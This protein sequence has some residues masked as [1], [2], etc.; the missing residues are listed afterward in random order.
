MGTYLGG[1]QSRY[2]SS[3]RRKDARGGGIRLGSQPCDSDRH[4]CRQSPRCRASREASEQAPAMPTV[5]NN[6]IGPVSRSLLR[7][8]NTRDRLLPESRQTSLRESKV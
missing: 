2:S 3:E 1:R 8:W 6:R 4:T 5:A 7:G